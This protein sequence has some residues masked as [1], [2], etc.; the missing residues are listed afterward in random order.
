[1]IYFCT[2]KVVLTPYPVEF[3][4]L[5]FHEILW[6]HIFH[7]LARNQKVT[8]ESSR[9]FHINLHISNVEQYHS[10]ASSA[11]YLGSPQSV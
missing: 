5:L 9:G 1:M 11:K 8:S 3:S 4:D 6:H 10:S 2:G 7:G